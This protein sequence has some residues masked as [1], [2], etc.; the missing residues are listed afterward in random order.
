MLAFDP[1]GGEG[2]RVD[3]GVATGGEVTPYYDPMIAKVIAS[4]P[5]RTEALERLADALD[6]VRVIGPRNAPFLAALLRTRGFRTGKS[7]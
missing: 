1:P 6:Q 2:I 3:A 5:T 4:A 7:T